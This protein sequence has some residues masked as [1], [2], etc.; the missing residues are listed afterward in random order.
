MELKWYDF[1]YNN[2]CCSITLMANDS[3]IIASGVNSMMQYKLG[4]ASRIQCGNGHINNYETVIDY[5]FFI[6]SPDKDGLIEVKKIVD[7]CYQKYLE[8]E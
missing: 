1:N 2:K 8:K 4:L 3:G 7:D 6:V 5:D